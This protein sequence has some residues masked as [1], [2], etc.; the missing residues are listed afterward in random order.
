M[1]TSSI[2]DLNIETN[3]LLSEFSFSESHC[4]DY[5]AHIV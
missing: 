1:I 5:S 3:N 4:L 2:T